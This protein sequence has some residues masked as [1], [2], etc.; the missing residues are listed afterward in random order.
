MITNLT[1]RNFQV[2]KKLSIDF[3]PHITC[4][5][6]A[7]DKGKSSIIRAIKWA[8]TNRPSPDQF[9]RNGTEFV[10]VELTVDDNTIKRKKS[11]KE[12][13]YII[14]SEKEFKAIRTDVPEEIST[15]LN[16]SAVNFQSQHDSPF[17]LSI[18]PG[19]V[20]RQLNGVINLDRID[21]LMSSASSEV[22]KKKTEIQIIDDRIAEK[23][24]E[25]KKYEQVDALNTQ[26]KNIEIQNNNRKSLIQKSILLKKLIDNYFELSDTINKTQDMVSEAKGLTDRIKSFNELNISLT[27]IKALVKYTK[28]LEADAN[29]SV[30]SIKII[31]ELMS[32]YNSLKSKNKLL[33]TIIS[34]YNDSVQNKKSVSREFKIIDEEYKSLL[35]ERCPL[36]GK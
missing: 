2:H 13:C 24:L 16:V 22:R 21:N 27:T 32:K 34:I 29:I 1:I 6:G 23:R 28:T 14:N 8:C 26:L 11:K 18:A 10:S 4:I 31:D 5:V 9:I 33:E 20:S 35:K 12:N 36:C 17:W 15:L 25:I 19:E 30:P 7:T 3:D